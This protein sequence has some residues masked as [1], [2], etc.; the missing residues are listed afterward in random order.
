[1]AASPVQKQKEGRFV[2]A[3]SLLDE[4]WLLDE[5]SWMPLVREVES[6]VNVEL[7]TNSKSAG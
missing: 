4:V 1:M 5:L 6:E 3:A 7:W 2:V